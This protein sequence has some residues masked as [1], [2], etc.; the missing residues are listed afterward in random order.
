MTS[1]QGKCS[2]RLAVLLMALLP[3]LLAPIVVQA[4][5]S[6]LDDESCLM[7]HKYPMMGRVTD[8]GVL[9]SY[10]VI[11]HVFGKTVHRNVP[12]RD[13]HTYINK[14]PHDPVKTGV[15]CNTECHSI[16]NPA[17]GKPF[18][19]KTIVEAYSSSIHGRNKIET[20]G[21]ADKPYCITCHTNPINNPHEDM[22]PKRITDRCVLCH[23]KQ[24]FVEQWYNHTSR[25]IR[26]VRRTPEQIV[27]LCSA[28]HGDRKLVEKHLELAK[29]ENRPIGRKFGIAVE[30]YEES[31]HGKLT[32]YGFTKTANCLDCHADRENYYRS[33]HEIR[34][35]RDPKSPVSKGRR[36]A[37]CKNC[38]TFADENYAALD[39]HPSSHPH[40]NL[41]RY[42]A[43]VIYNMVGN[44]VI[45]LLVGMSLFET[46]G[47]WRDGVTWR[48]K[49][50]SSWWRRSKRGR[51]R[52]L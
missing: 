41:F 13:C 4:Q 26:E 19:H 7:C 51:D 14:L 22:P 50:G 24:S 37:T 39:P 38:H 48:L 43:E 18:S 44:V 49:Q 34:P 1:R 32:K 33:V 9:R 36:V 42:W 45:V 40:D 6:A 15:T 21:A 35:S 23:E 47:R 12:C 2:Y 30:S 17:T 46:W 31:F 5:G 20:G 52:V 25:R 28:C 16:K 11:P 27:E 8:E 3:A 29:K 10:Y